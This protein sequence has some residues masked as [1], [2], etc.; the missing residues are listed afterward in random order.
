MTKETFYM[1]YAEHNNM[2]VFKHPTYNSAL[3]EAKRLTTILKVPCYILEAMQ[4]VKK[5][6]FVITDLQREN[7]LPF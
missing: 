3:E 1:I 2:P 7:E 5:S 6:D 4:V